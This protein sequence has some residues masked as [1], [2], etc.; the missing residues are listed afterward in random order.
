MANAEPSVLFLDTSVVRQ[1]FDGN[2][3]ER[4]ALLAEIQRAA[5]TAPI[6]VP[7]EVLHEL[8]EQLK[9]HPVRW[10]TW[11]DGRRELCS[12]VDK[13]G[14]IGEPYQK[15]R[16]REFEERRVGRP[17]V[18]AEIGK[19][20][21]DYP[22]IWRAF[23]GASTAETFR[24]WSADGVSF[25]FDELAEMKTKR[26]AQAAKYETIAAFQAACAEHGVAKILEPYIAENLGPDEEIRAR[27][28]QLVAERDAKR[29]LDE[30]DHQDR[31]MLYDGLILLYCTVP[32]AMLASLENRHFLLLGPESILKPK[33]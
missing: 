26:L 10:R 32:G 30:S 27:V 17:A 19:R 15:A 4:T 7:I 18:E 13:A 6:R 31:N 16:V 9:A 11:S 14:P 29:K 21:E 24:M 20:N 5:G 22:K 1:I 25:N 28:L 2:A 12:V 33:V 8:A 23:C 3:E